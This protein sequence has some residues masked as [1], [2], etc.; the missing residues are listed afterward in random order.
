MERQI[1]LKIKDGKAEKEYPL[2]I[3]GNAD[4]KWSRIL[5][6]LFNDDAVKIKD[7]VFKRKYQ[8]LRAAIRSMPV[9]R[10]SLMIMSPHLTGAETFVARMRAM[11]LKMS[12]LGIS[13]LVLTGRR[14]W[15]APV[16]LTVEVTVRTG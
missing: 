10:I 6:F 1:V 5:D 16:I 15:S 4:D 12:S 13:P 7:V 8:A 11:H 3:V 2:R 9:P 14:S